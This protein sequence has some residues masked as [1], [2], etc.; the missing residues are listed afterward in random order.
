ML[1]VSVSTFK[2]PGSVCSEQVFAVSSVNEWN[3]LTYLTQRKLL[4]DQKFT[5]SGVI[6]LKTIT[7]SLIQLNLIQF[8]FHS[9]T[10]TEVI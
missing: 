3:V 5:D 8:Y 4:H 1:F 10:I 2:L 7:F 6:V 9:T